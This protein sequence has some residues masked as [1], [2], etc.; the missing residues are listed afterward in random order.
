MSSKIILN[1]S[2]KNNNNK[3]NNK[4]IKTI[5]NDNFRYERNYFKNNLCKTYKINNNRSN[6]ESMTD[7]KDIY[8]QNTN[9]ASVHP[10]SP[11]PIKNISFRARLKYYSNKK[12]KEL[13]KMMNKKLEEEKQIYTFHPKTG[14]NELN[15]IK[16]NNSIKDISTIKKLNNNKKRKV[17]ARRIND[18]YLDYKDK[19][20]NIDRM[21][22]D[23][24]KQ[25]GYSFTPC[26]RDN[27]KEIK[28]FKFKIGQI[29]YIDRIEIYGHKRGLNNTIKNNKNV[30]YSTEI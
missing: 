19:K 23:Y 15:V 28:K 24:Y 27:N 1:S 2:D 3:N 4:N 7:K 10:L 20:Y 9:Y 14:E 21:T 8:N 5:N 12:E 6:N 22:R 16:Y 26:I 25:A 18:L 11:L 30:F 17:N 13:K 29:P